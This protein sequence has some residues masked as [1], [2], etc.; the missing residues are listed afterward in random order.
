MAI[1]Q[2]CRRIRSALVVHTLLVL[3]E[4]T[5]GLSRLT[6]RRQLINGCVRF[7]VHVL[8]KLQQ[9]EITAPIVAV[10]S[11]CEIEPDN[12]LIRKDAFPYQ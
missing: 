1:M 6:C 9:N 5:C 3:Q 12:T 4:L 2:N 8:D 11:H 10:S 7:I